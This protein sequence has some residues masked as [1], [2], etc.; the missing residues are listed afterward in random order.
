MTP[1]PLGLAP[2][3]ASGRN[4][5]ASG[6]C[7]EVGVPRSS[8]RADED[9]AVELT[10]EELRLC[11]D[12]AGKRLLDLGCGRGESCVTFAS[13]GAKVIGIDQSA[14]DL[15]YARRLVEE[16]ERRVELRHGD[17]ADLA[18]LPPASVDVAF[19][20]GALSYVSDPGRVFRQVHRVL[21]TGAP[22][23]FSVVHPASRLDMSSYWAG[24]TI[25]DLYG[26]LQRANF[27][28]DTLLEPEPARTA[29]PTLAPQTLVMRGR[30]LGL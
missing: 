12:V 4:V 29:P 15:A 11:G 22:L 20:A 23:V 13:R 2:R 6:Y 7:A 3:R 30:K 18:F 8:R 25:A 17:L 26:G 19:S 5:T 10:D 28:V 21:K 27:E 9:G 24:Y 1:G 14:D 16:E